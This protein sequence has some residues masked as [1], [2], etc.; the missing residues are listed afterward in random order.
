MMFTILVVLLVAVTQ[1]SATC[2]DTAGNE[3]DTFFPCNATA[4]VSV[5]CSGSDYCLDNGLCLDTGGD[6]IFTVQGCTSSTWEAPCKQ[7]CP[8][9]PPT[10]N[11]YQDLTLCK[12][13]DKVSGEYCCGQ[14]ASC[15]DA[16]DSYIS[17]PIFKSVFKA[18]AVASPSDTATSSSSTSSSSPSSS[19]TSNPSPTPSPSGKSSNS[20]L[21]VGLGV[22]L[23]L[24]LGLL[25]LA[26][27][28]LAWEWRKRNA[29][30]RITSL[31]EP[32]QP[33]VWTHQ[34]YRHP[35]PESTQN[36]V[37][38]DQNYVPPQELHPDAMKRELPGDQIFSYRP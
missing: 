9:L 36:I 19:S 23:G 34:D 6:N 11:W 38:V 7:Y 18:P 2:Y 26:L 3:H 28:F 25:S 30:S 1:S 33:T 12:S 21:G 17:L 15:C 8:G 10:Q 22:G 13:I 35:T 16:T 31:P 29:I 32:A 5:C 27:A 4:E 20:S 24:G 14:N 37:W